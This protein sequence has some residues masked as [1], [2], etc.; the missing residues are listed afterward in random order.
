MGGRRQNIFH[1]RATSR[2][3]LRAGSRFV[4]RMMTV[5]ATLKQQQR[6]VVDYITLACEATLR[7]TPVP[8]LL[9]AHASPGMR[10]QAA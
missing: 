4:E 2:P 6:N 1:T 5:A 10:V 3:T 7:G 9:P 8:T